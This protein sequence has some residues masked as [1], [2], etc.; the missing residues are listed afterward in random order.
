MA[1]LWDVKSGQELRVFKGQRDTTQDV[2]FTPNGRL[3]IVTCYD[4]KVRIWDLSRVAPPDK[5]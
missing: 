5:P 3:G 1:R 4:R 2:A